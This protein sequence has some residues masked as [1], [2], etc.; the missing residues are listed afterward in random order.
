[1]N[2][3][4]KIISCPIVREDNGLAMSSRNQR[5]SAHEFEQAAII[6]QTISKLPEL[7]H[8]QDLFQI[9]KWMKERID[10][11]PLFN[12]EYVELVDSESLKVVTRIKKS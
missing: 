3:S 7:I 10:S 5:L 11:N 9:K 1:M 6:F 2:S 4:V 8:S 12:T